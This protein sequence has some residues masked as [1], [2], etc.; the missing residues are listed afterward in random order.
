[1]SQNRKRTLE[2][3]NNQNNGDSKLPNGNSSNGNELN[4]SGPVSKRSLI[5][6]GNG[7]SIAP[8]VNNA[9]LQSLKQQVVVQRPS[10]K[11]SKP[12]QSINLPGLPHEFLF[13]AIQNIK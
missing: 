3:A 10:Q 7:N 5:N 11:S 13:R 9:K 12:M 6:N 8:A 4:D 1:M 2:Q